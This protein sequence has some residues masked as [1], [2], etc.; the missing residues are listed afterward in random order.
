[1][2]CRADCLPSAGNRG[3]QWEYTLQMTALFIDKRGSKTQQSMHRWDRLPNDSNLDVWVHN[4][5]RSEHCRAGR[6]RAILSA[7]CPLP[8]KQSAI[9]SHFY[10]SDCG[11]KKLQSCPHLGETSKWASMTTGE[12]QPFRQIHHNSLQPCFRVWTHSC[13]K[14]P[15]Q[16]FCYHP[17]GRSETTTP[18]VIQTAHA[19]QGSTQG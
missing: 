9:N 18:C 14:A 4:R 3:F 2:P 10:H 19:S 15:S 13:T 8:L 17:S 6:C 16:I 1:M 5:V 12:L 7:A 11:G